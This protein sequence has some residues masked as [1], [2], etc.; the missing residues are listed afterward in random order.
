M[1]CPKTWC[2]YRGLRCEKFKKDELDP[3][4]FLLREVKDKWFK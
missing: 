3:P 2:E 4:K 1:K